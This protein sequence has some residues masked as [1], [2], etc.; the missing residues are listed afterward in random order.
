MAK[1]GLQLIATM[2]LACGGHKAAATMPD[3]DSDGASGTAEGDIIP[4]EKMDQVDQNLKRRGTQVSHCLARAINTGDVPRGTRGRITF[5]IRI[6]TDGHASSVRVIKSEIENQ[7]VVDC[8]TKLVEDTSFPT[9]PR[10]YETSYTYGL[11]AS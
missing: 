8:A 7:S 9:L 3:P 5:G 4:P 2:L 10:A 1:F 11:D 6:G